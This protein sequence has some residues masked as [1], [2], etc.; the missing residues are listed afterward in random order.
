[1]ATYDIVVTLGVNMA[2]KYKGS[3]ITLQDADDALSQTYKY[4]IFFPKYNATL[5][6]PNGWRSKKSTL[7][8]WIWTRFK[9]S[10]E[11]RYPPR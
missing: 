7:K 11:Y 2:F 5:V 3:Y 1:M 6:V 8:K 10:E 9:G 4:N